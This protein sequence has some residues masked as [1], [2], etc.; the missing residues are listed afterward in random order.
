MSFVKV[1]GR[2]WAAA[3]REALPATSM[4]TTDRTVFK[5]PDERL[6]ASEIDGHVE[7]RKPRIEYGRRRQPGRAVGDRIV[8]LVVRRSRVAV[9]QVVKVDGDVGPR[10]A[11]P[12]DLAGA[13]VERV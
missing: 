12:Q 11:E 2:S 4:N 8:R 13:D 3:T 10:P 7:P 1:T 9:E 5:L 6:R